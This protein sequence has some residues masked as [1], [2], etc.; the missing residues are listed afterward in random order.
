MV[1]LRSRR[2]SMRKDIRT[3]FG[4]NRNDEGRLSW[5]S[6]TLR[7]ILALGV[8]VYADLLLLCEQHR[9]A[10]FDDC[11]QQR[12]QSHRRRWKYSDA[13]GQRHEAR[14]AAARPR[15]RK[16]SLG[17]YVSPRARI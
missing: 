3:I 4:E 8:I 1:E 15:S 7:S 2:G 11:P 16:R 13:A 6:I 9:A 10:A 12:A 17:C 14:E 5:V